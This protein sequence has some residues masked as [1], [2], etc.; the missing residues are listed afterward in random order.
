M[1]LLARGGRSLKSMPLWILGIKVTLLLFI[2]F[3]QIMHLH[4]LNA[5]A[6]LRK[7]GERCVVLNYAVFTW[8]PF[9]A[10]WKPHHVVYSFD[11]EGVD[12]CDEADTPEAFRG[13]PLGLL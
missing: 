7:S 8:N 1:A 5:K 12:Y 9:P 3:T 6:D 10:H 13:R 2:A 11:P 4:Y